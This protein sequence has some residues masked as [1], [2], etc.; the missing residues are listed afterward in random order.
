MTNSSIPAK[1]L[2]DL[3]RR[4]GA[5][6]DPLHAALE[7]CGRHVRAKILRDALPRQRHA[8]RDGERQQNVETGAR[9]IDPAVAQAVGLL[10]N[11]GTDERDRGGESNRG[12]DEVGPREGRHLREVAHR[13]F[14]RVG[15]PV[16]RRQERD[17]RVPGDEASHGAEVLRIERQPVLETQNGV[18]ERSAAEADAEQAAGVCR[19]RHLARGIHPA[20]AVDDPLERRDD[21]REPRRLA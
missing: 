11:E 20:D 12:R 6:G 2:D 3:L 14:A 16:G 21:R 19:P 5:A 18:D 15:L 10:A 7:R 9:E 17:R 8:A 13:A 4:H 1:Q